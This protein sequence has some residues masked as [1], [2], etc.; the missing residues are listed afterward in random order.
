MVVYKD[1]RFL[2]QYDKDKPNK[3]NALTWEVMHLKVAAHIRYFIDMSLY[4]NFDEETDTNILW[5]KIGFMFE[6]NNVVNR[7]CIFRKIVRLR[8]QDGSS[9]VEH[10]NAFHGLINQMASLEVPLAYEVLAF[11]VA[12]LASRHLGDTFVDLG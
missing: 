3:I 2:I 5:K 7:V 1:L 11:N 9:M 4:K 6:N 12:R 8:Y 10:L